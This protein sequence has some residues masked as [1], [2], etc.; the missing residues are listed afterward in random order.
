MMGG[1]TEAG[2]GFWSHHRHGRARET[3]RALPDAAAFRAAK[4][5]MSGP[6]SAAS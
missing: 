2:Q 6:S 5:T 4:Q 3:G 1:R